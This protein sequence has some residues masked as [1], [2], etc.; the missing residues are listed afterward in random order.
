M[1][2]LEQKQFQKRQVACKILISSIINGQFGKDES[3]AGYVKINGNVV[4][5][6]NFIGNLVY[7]MEENGYYNAIIDDGTAKISLKSFEKKAFFSNID[8]GDIIL[9][10]GKVREYGNERYV[11][12]EII[13]KIDASWMSLR[14]LELKDE[15]IVCKAEVKDPSENI[16]SGKNVYELIKKLD[17]G[18]GTAMEDLIGNYNGDVEKIVNK[19][20]ENGDVFEIKPGR[21]KV[22][23]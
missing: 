3:S 21:L 7:K 8:V 17:V 6:V 13:K 14:K 11:M 12:P 9:V 23:E 4:S 5:R 22:L 10:V 1:P 15:A 16:D 18:D 20:L 2:E 19:L